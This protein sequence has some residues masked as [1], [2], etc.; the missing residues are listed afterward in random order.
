MGRAYPSHREEM[1]GSERAAQKGDP[2]GF[3][4]NVH[5]IAS[6]GQPIRLPPQAS[7]MVDYEGEV[8]IIFGKPTH[9]VSAANAMDHVFGFTI[10]NDVSA[11]SWLPNAKPG[12]NDKNRMGKQFPTFLPTGPCV[13]S[14]DEFPDPQDLHLVTRV[15]GEMRQD[16]LTSQLVWSMPEMIEYFSFWYPFAA[17][18]MLVT[19][20]PGGVGYGRKPQIFLKSGDTVTVTVDGIGVLENTVA[21]LGNR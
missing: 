12:E 15:N 19:G 5:A 16:T 20:T 11:R 2:T 21:P 6:P 18:D 4:Q 1:M 14:K 7:D 17:G 10:C 8:A 9:N 13:V 3:I